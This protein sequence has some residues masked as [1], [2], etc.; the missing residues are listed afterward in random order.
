M[1]PMAGPDKEPELPAAQIIPASEEL[2]DSIVA[3]ATEVKN[4]G[5]FD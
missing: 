3:M 2:L 5:Y 1:V 4:L